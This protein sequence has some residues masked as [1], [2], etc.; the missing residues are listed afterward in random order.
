[1]D[2][3]IGRTGHR[4]IAAIFVLLG[5]LGVGLV[6]FA[7][8]RNVAYLWG[9]GLLFA[10]VGILVQY[11]FAVLATQDD[12]G[13]SSSSRSR[14]APMAPPASAGSTS[15]PEWGFDFDV[16]QDPAPGQRTHAPEPEP[17]PTPRP[18]PEPQR[19]PEQP[20]SA[21]EAKVSFQVRDPR[22]WPGQGNPAPSSPRNKLDEKFPKR[23][24]GRTGGGTYTPPP[25][26][27]DRREKLTDK[28]TQNTPT[29]RSILQE[30][31]RSPDPQIPARPTGGPTNL[32]PPPPGKSRGTCGQCG[33]ILLAPTQ[34]PIKI[35]CPVCAKTTVLE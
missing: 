26:S 13:S 18:A 20:A 23:H 24:P 3:G 8:D 10:T 16:P 29:V 17:R 21:A 33:T 11:I 19:P 35:K 4:I 15:D 32:P 34:R 5:L 9:L 27:E 30:K 12:G 31:A 6:W 25:P 14:P 7:I 1:M 2:D 22:A 28:Y